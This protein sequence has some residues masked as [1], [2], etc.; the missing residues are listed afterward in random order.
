MTYRATPV[1]SARQ[2]KDFYRMPF[3]VYDHD[4]NWVPPITSEVRRVLNVKR[5]PY[6]TKTKLK[7]FVCYKDNG[8]ASRTAIIINRLHQQK[9]GVKSAFFGFFES[10]GDVNAV[11]CLFDEAESYCKS[12][13]MELLEGPFNPNHY[14]ELG[15]QM[16]QFGTS[17]TF[18]QPYNPDYYSN[19]LEEAGFQVSARFHSLK[20]ENIREYIF[21]RY[22]TRPI[23][24]K[25]GNYTIRSFSRSDSKA[26]FERIREVYNDAFSSNW[27][28]LPLSKEEY[29]FSAKYMSLVTRPDLIK[30]V[31]HKG[32]PV[33]VFHCV[34]DINPALKKMKGKVGPVKYM[35]FLL[36]RRK[37]RKL[38]LYSVGIKKSYQHSRVYKLLLTTFYQLC[39]KYNV[40][41]TTWTS[42]ENIPAMKAAEHLG[43]KPDKQFAIFEKYLLI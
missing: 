42:E 28:F 37:T 27:H 22:G 15:L 18:F 9:M 10:I 6:F 24:H 30:I 31:E 3:I 35:R 32:E 20:N 13:G 21:Q 5:N 17:P 33:A 16:N 40:L 43:L 8:I 41:E 39:V 1:S 23:L 26:E 14:S 19:L 7:L 11:R 38:I 4:P 34:L 25:S 2:M 36:N 12:H 29:L